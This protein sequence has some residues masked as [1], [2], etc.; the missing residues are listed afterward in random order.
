MPHGPPISPLRRA[1]YRHYDGFPQAFT[2]RSRDAF[3]RIKS[4]PPSQGA[5]EPP[6]WA[7]I[8]AALEAGAHPPC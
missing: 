1:A 5:R 2:T 4:S 8:P 6:R 7:D 3:L